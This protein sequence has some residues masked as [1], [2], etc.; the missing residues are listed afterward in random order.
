MNFNYNVFLS[1]VIRC[2]MS[3]QMRECLLGIVQLHIE[4]PYMQIN[5]DVE[6]L[7]HAMEDK[8]AMGGCR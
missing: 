5:R 8:N 7:L 3:E 2:R 4:N 6:Y 1:T